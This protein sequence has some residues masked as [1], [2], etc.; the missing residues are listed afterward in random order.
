MNEFNSYPSYTQFMKR[1]LSQPRLY[2]NNLGIIIDFFPQ[3]LLHQH[4]QYLVKFT[5]DSAMLTIK[6]SIVI[7]SF[8]HHASLII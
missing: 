3:I 2:E 7:A 6:L 1:K 8:V 5:N 4:V